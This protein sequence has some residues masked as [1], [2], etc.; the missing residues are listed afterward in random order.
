MSR[1]AMGAD[2][3]RD[4]F[5][6]QPRE[7]APGEDCPTPDAIWASA[8]GEL[9]PEENR[10]V[11]D[12]TGRCPSCAEDWRLAR[13]VGRPTDKQPGRLATGTTGTIS[14]HR[15]L[16]AAAVV[17]IAVLGGVELH[18][19]RTE[20]HEVVLRDQPGEAIESL[21]PEDQPLSRDHA[22]LRWSGFEGATYELFVL[23][24]R[25]TVLVRE[26]GLTESRYTLPAH[27]LAELDSGTELLWHVEAVLP[28]GSRVASQTFRVRIE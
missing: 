22:T 8:H 26:E 28:D 18:Q 16:A 20:D 4:L 2:D 9:P 7:I 3:L 15:W 11:I 5:Q 6:G 10:R 24:P 14:R 17:L 19:I 12:H 1:S 21:T 25:V 23:A 27:A 13:F